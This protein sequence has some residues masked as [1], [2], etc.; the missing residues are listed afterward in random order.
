MVSH[1]AYTN[2]APRAGRDKV[3][4]ASIS[5]FWIKRVLQRKI[6]YRGLVISDD[7]EMGGVLEH[8]SIEEAA[9]AAVAAG[10]HLIEV[11]KDP[12]LVLRAFEALLR[13]AESSRA[14]RRFVQ[15]AAAKVRT[16]KRRL[17]GKDT[18]GKA[19]TDQDVRDIRERVEHFSAEVHAGTSAA[20]HGDGRDAAAAGDLL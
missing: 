1:A 18:L 11:C 8:S 4:P 20:I 9:V 13:E 19:P 16:S 3:P 14:F 2:A 6:G 12:A 15:G 7:M 10:T 17:L 5:P